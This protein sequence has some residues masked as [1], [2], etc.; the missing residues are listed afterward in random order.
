MKNGRKCYFL[1]KENDEQQTADKNKERLTVIPSSFLGEC[2]ELKKIEHLHQK[3]TL[4]FSVNGEPRLELSLR[5]HERLRVTKFLGKDRTTIMMRLDPHGGNYPILSIQD[6]RDGDDL[7]NWFLNH[8]NFSANLFIENDESPYLE[9]KAGIKKIFE[10]SEEA[11]TN[12][13]TYEDEKEKHKSE[14]KFCAY[15]VGSALLS[16]ANSGGGLLILG[17]GEDK[18]DEAGIKRRRLLR[19]DPAYEAG[20]ISSTN[21]IE[22]FIRQ[23][24]LPPILPLDGGPWKA[25]GNHAQVYVYAEDKEEYEVWRTRIHICMIPETEVFAFFTPAAPRPIRLIKIEAKKAPIAQ[26]IIRQ[27]S[28]AKTSTLAGKSIRMFM[29]ARDGLDYRESFIQLAYKLQN[30][31]K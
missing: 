5:G 7:A 23:K 29:D 27:G 13:K 25:E 6:I 24:I 19:L 22:E 11:R 28:A 8:K 14:E 26:L 1:V 10:P 17:V 16:M 2:T 12:K 30:L 4:T 31:L 9:Y 3:N 21:G 15:R 18:K 20:D